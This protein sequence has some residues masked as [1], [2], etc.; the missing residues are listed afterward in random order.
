MRDFETR[1]ADAG[2]GWRARPFVLPGIG[3]V[4]HAP[5]DGAQLS[6]MKAALAAGKVEVRPVAARQVFV[7]G[8]PVGDPF[9]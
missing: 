5:V 2:E 3:I 1:G 9:E 8:V 4:E 7:G 6:A